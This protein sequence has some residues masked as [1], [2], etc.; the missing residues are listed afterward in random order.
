MRI[1]VTPIVLL[2]SVSYVHAARADSSVAEAEAVHTLTAIPLR[3][4]FKELTEYC[5]AS[6]VEPERCQSAAP[7]A[8]C[9]A[10]DAPATLAPP[11]L[12]SRILFIGGSP[13]DCDLALR[14][15]DF[16]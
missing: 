6:D 13:G 5:A 16:T 9:G 10:L 4:P 14:T 15:C 12:E 1:H 7:R 3:G 11:F 8:A 2:L